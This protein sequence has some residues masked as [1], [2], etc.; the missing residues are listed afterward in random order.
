MRLPCARAEQSGL[1]A[2]NSTLRLYRI[3]ACAAEF[4]RSSLENAVKNAKNWLGSRILNTKQISVAATPWLIIAGLLYAGL[5]IK[6]KAVGKEFR[7]PPIERRDNFLDISSPEPDV[8][9]AVGLAG[10]VVRSNDAGR[11]WIAQNASIT[12]NLQSIAAWDRARAVA[13]GNDGAVIVTAD[14]G[15]HWKEV[16]A[17]RSG[18]SNKLIRVVALPGGEAWAVGEM[19]ALLHTTNHG[20]TWDRVL[21]EQ[22]AAFNDITFIGKK[23]WIVG[24]FGKILKSEDGGKTWSP[25]NSPV[26]S[27]LM[28]VDFRD[29][30]NGVAVGLEGAILH[31]QDG[32]KIW[33][34]LPRLA[35]E[36]LFDVKAA[37]DGWWAAGDKGTF[38]RA[39]TSGQKW[40]SVSFDNGNA[41][42]V[43]KILISGGQIYFAGESLNALN[44]G[45]WRGL[46]GLN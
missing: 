32:G 21:N 6:P 14:G 35:R 4:R 7:A 27:S 26:K 36:H 33:T 9:W 38:L 12:A 34:D 30:S 17:P 46:G 24:E 25:A 43:T 3:H 19:G 41:G 15:E 8:L 11:S 28:A 10:K 1:D 45:R 2:I 44:D 31:T 42:W 37:K 5:F 16:N 20:D 29:E 39:D 40:S 18:V 22:D 23:G 13:V